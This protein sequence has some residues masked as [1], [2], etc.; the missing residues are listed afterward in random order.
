MH[1]P[2]DR[3]T[4][5]TAFVTPVVE[6]WLEREIAQWVHLMKD[7]SDDPPHH[8][9]TLYLWA[10]SH[11]LRFSQSSP[12]H[13]RAAL[14]VSNDKCLKTVQSKMWISSLKNDTSPNSEQW[15]LILFIYYIPNKIKSFCFRLFFFFSFLFQTFSY[16]KHNRQWDWSNN[17]SILERKLRWCQII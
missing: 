16:Y 3:I 7:R 5:T 10:T 13:S 9:R 4:H 17:I 14:L 11:S 15:L 8:E 2:T 12:L 1:H 6:H